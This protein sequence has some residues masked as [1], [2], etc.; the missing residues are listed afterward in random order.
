LGAP[1]EIAVVTILDAAQK[2]FA[3]HG[4][5]GASIAEVARVAG[6]PKANIHY[7]FSTK[8]TLYQ[9]VLRRTMQEWLGGC[10]AWLKPDMPATEA[11]EGYIEAKLAFSRSNPQASRVFAHE[12]LGGARYLQDYISSTLREA[13]RPFE[14]TIAVWMDRQEIP[15]GDPL[16]F[17]FCLWAM[18][19]WYA[20]MQPQLTG[21]L[22]QKSLEE[23]DFSAAARTILS[24]VTRA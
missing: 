13:I 11:L 2:V 5:S 4:F 18:T 21:L 6:I 10:E 7:Y 19:Q 14:A 3:E 8:E 17:L 24:L 1:R 23:K 16:H 22:G 20:D 12:I 9:E 15:R